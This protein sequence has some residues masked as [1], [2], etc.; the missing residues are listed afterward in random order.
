MLV[1]PGWMHRPRPGQGLRLAIYKLL[2]ALNLKSTQQK[3]EEHFSE[4]ATSRERRVSLCCRELAIKQRPSK[5]GFPQEGFVPAGGTA[6][7]YLG[8]KQ[9]PDSQ[10]VWPSPFMMM[11]PLGKAHI[12]HRRSSLPVTTMSFLGCKAKL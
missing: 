9:Q 6:S 5:P 3:P 7:A 10:S 4:R 11:L 1:I 12:F 2:T 8:W